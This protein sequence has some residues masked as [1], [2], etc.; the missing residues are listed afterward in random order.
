VAAKTRNIRQIVPGSAKQTVLRALVEIRFKDGE[1][2]LKTGRPQRRIGAIYVAGYG[3]E[4][5]LKA[6]ICFDRSARYL[7]REFH[8]HDLRRLAEA[9]SLWPRIKRD[10]SRLGRLRYLQSEWHVTM[11][12]AARPYDPSTVRDF[13]TRAREFTRWLF[14]D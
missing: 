5:A 4:C 12:Y 6:R 1:A 8:H 7:D 3:V 9:T 10:P 13:I 14:D 2:L 11:R